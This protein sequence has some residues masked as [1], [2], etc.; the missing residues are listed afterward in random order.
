MIPTGF[1]THAGLDVAA[2]E[3]QARAVL[4]AATYAYFAGGSGAE[5]TVAAN[6]EAWTRLRLR[7]RVLSGVGDADPRTTVLGTEIAAPV[8]AGP[9]AYHSLA[10]PQAERA[11]AAGVAAAHSV[12]VV[13]AR[14]TV[15]LAE[16]AAA[17][18]PWWFQ[19]YVMRD[20]SVSDELVRQAV[21]AGARALVLTGDTP[22]TGRGAR[23]AALAIPDVRRSALASLDVDARAVEQAPDASWDD[24]ARLTDHGLP[25]LVKGVLR[26][27]DALACLD[28][29]AAGVIVSN[30]GG[31]QLDGSIATADALPE[32][33]AAVGGRAE[34]YVDGGIRHGE[35]V[36]RALALGARAVLIGRPVLWGLAVG[37]AGGI[38]R[39]LDDFA[40]DVARAMTIA[41]MPT[42]DRLPPG[43]LD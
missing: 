19:S 13:S 17:A 36:V 28:A 23:D 39:L 43:L 5:T 16:V 35:D 33:V 30:H 6:R 11:T 1:V 9:T 38:R 27:D 26:S 37:G 4:T 34:V 41:G 10:H 40:A 25:V 21:A 14:C 3:R 22:I 12:Y 2:L 42:V 32:V 20:R 18:G 7:P 8:L 29:G 15:P 31:R 24:L